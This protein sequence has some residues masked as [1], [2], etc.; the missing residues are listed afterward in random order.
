MDMRLSH[1]PMVQNNKVNGWMEDMWGNNWYL[2]SQAGQ[3][4]S[5]VKLKQVQSEYLQR[6]V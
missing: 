6:G 5:F 2:L 3:K 1:I 4:M